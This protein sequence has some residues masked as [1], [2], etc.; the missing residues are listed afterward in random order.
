MPSPYVGG[1][2]CGKKIARP[3]S[4]D[5]QAGQVI[6]ARKI[7]C[8]NAFLDLRGPQSQLGP[9]VAASHQIRWPPRTRQ[10]RVKISFTPLR[11]TPL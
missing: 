2:S 6:F 3:D 4:I 1:I 11:P 5:S 7:F 10:K 9:R 8:T